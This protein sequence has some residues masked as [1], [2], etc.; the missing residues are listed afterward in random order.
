MSEETKFISEFLDNEFSINDLSKL[1]PTIIK[2]T[3]DYLKALQPHPKDI[4]EDGKNKIKQQL[5]QLLEETKKEDEVDSE[6]E[7]K[8]L[9]NTNKQKIF[10]LFLDL[11]YDSFVLYKDKWN[12]LSEDDKKEKDYFRYLEEK[13]NS[14]ALWR[15]D[16]GIEFKKL[17]ELS[18]TEMNEMRPVIQN[19]FVNKNDDFVVPPL[20]KDTYEMD[21]F[22]KYAN[23]IMF[24]SGIAGGGG[25]KHKYKQLIHRTQTR[26][27]I[28]RHRKS[29]RRRRTISK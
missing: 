14:L 21:A 5:R 25:G 24:P 16:G 27:S 17:N 20:Y 12:K 19:S 1:H 4:V 9:I 7:V 6:G 3:N 18:D 26:K 28:K 29:T 8:E 2:M 10:N 15:G 13:F 22:K 11:F 23:E